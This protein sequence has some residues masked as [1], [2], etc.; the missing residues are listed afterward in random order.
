M[1]R[2]RL[3]CSKEFPVVTMA[4]SEMLALE[5][6]I[7]VERVRVRWVQLSNSTLEILMLLR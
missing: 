4:V 5:I 1:G 7:L 6:L 2:P 3:R